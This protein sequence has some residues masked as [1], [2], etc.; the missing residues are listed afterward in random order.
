[1]LHPPSSSSSSSS[2]ASSSSSPSSSV[3]SN[4]KFTSHLP[5]STP[6]PTP[7]PT[8]HPSNLVPQTY[9]RVEPKVYF[10]NERTFLAWLNFT[11]LLV[12]FSVGLMNFHS[13]KKHEGGHEGVFLTYQ[14]W[15]GVVL[16]LISLGC[17]VYALYMYLYRARL[18]RQRRSG[19]YEDTWSPMVVVTILMVT[20]LVNFLLR[21]LWTDLSSSP[22]PSP[23]PS[24]SPFPT[25]PVPSTMGS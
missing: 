17:M 23:T 21:F 9:I 5:T 14:E 13:E 16:T 19:P 12:G 22:S 11:L 8:P 25:P 2:S 4:L 7:T 10:A 1:M 20:I 3:L 18:I 6:T 24:P 15:M